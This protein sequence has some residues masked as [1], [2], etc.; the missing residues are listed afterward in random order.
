ME[1][2]QKEKNKNL[3]NIFDIT[4]KKCER[5]AIYALISEGYNSKNNYRSDSIYKSFKN[6][7]YD[8]NKTEV[9]AIFASNQ[10]PKTARY[11]YR[12]DKKMDIIKRYDEL[13]DG[14]N[15]FLQ[16]VEENS[17]PHKAA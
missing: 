11:L 9:Y 10:S 14:M 17:S 7:G 1:G 15:K 4:F 6:Q 2:F 5:I 8:V 12:E 3:I 16:I 13:M